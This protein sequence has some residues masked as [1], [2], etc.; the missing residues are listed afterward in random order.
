MSFQ[1][2]IIQ[3][4][5]I[6]VHDFPHVHRIDTQPPSVAIH[7]PSLRTVRFRTA[8]RSGRF[9]VRTKRR[10][11]ATTVCSLLL[12]LGNKLQTVYLV[13]STSTWLLAV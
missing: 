5:I 6:Q 10:L 11:L 12:V 2:Q 8:E 3:V 13:S 4:Q 1:I 7:L 9:A